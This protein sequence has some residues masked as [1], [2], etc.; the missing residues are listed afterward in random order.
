[1]R[2]AEIADRT[3]AEALN[4]AVLF[5]RVAP[6]EQTGVADEYFDHQLCGLTAT[7][8]AGI[9]LG[10]VTDVVHLPGQDLLA[11]ATAAGER[12]VPFVAALVPTVDLAGG[13]VIVADLPGLLD[14]AAETAAGGAG[15]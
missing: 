9:D 2:F 13:R 15:E 4:G 14:D 3:A 7:S 1:M 8:T 12:L 5:A 11:I 10:P 6:D